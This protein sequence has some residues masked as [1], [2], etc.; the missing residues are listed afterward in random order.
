MV[1]RREIQARLQVSAKPLQEAIKVQDLA[2]GSRADENVI[3]DDFRP[4]QKAAGGRS[5]CPE[6]AEFLTDPPVSAALCCQGA[7]L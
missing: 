1:P 2:A 4:F 3:G 6:S 7:F 5:S